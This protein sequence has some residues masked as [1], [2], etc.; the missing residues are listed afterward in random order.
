MRATP[1]RR[2]WATATATSSAALRASGTGASTRGPSPSRE[3]WYGRGTADNK[4]QHLI[5]ML[6][7][8]M[9]VAERGRLGFNSRFVIET[10]EEIG[11]PGMSAFCAVH[12][13]MLAA[14]LLIGSDGPGWRLIGRL[15]SAGR[16][17]R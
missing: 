1:C 10:S 17:A 5:N 12:K 9:V 11:S 2:C 15:S 8:E 4:S 13:D 7:L 6:A 16:A 14:D 3:S